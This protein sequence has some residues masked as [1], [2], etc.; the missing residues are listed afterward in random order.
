L[1]IVFAIK[2]H[3]FDELLIFIL[4]KVNPTKDMKYSFAV[5]VLVNHV[6]ALDWMCIKDHAY[7][8][9]EEKCAWAC[10]GEWED[11]NRY[12]CKHGL[13]EWTCELPAFAGHP[14]CKQFAGKIAAK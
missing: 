13:S 7:Y 9:K 10:A 1:V 5:A 12:N 14:G 11:R 2:Y 8:L 3:D 4:F 6:T